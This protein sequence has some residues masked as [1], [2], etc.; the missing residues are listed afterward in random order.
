MPHTGSITTEVFLSLDLLSSAELRILFSNDGR[1]ETA[2]PFSKTITAELR[3]NS[4]TNLKAKRAPE[5]RKA[6]LSFFAGASGGP[7]SV[8]SC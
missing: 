4:T 6:A 5:P 8:L 3:L 1:F 2:A 7:Q